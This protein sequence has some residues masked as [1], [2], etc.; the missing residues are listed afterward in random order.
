[1]QPD[2]GFPNWNDIPIE[3]LSQ[4]EVLKGAAS[5]L[6][7]SAA[8]NGIINFRSSFVKTEPETRFS[9]SSTVFL[10]P[11]DIAKKWWKDTLRYEN[12]FTFV[13]KQKFGKLDLIASGLYNK[14]EGFNQFT[15]ESR[16]RGNLNLRYRLTDRLSFQLGLLANASKSNSFFL[17]SNPGSGAMKPL[18]GTV[19]DKMSKRF[20]IDPSVTLYDKYNNKHRLLTRTILIDNQNNTNQSNTS[21]NQYCEYQFQRNFEKLKLVMTTGAVAAWSKTNSQILGDTTF[22][23]NNDALYLQLDKTFG[24]LIIAGGL[25]YEYVRQRSPENFMGTIIP[26]G[27]ASDDQLISRLSANYSFSEYSSLRASFGQ[28]YRYPTLTE[29]F[30]TTTFG[31]FSIFSNPKLRPEYG[32]SSEI[33]FKQGIKLGGFSGFLDGAVFMSE[34]EDMIEFTFVYEPGRFGFQPQNVGNTR[35][36]GYEVSILG[37]Q[38]IFGIPLIILGG[39]TY[40]N[41]VYKNYDASSQIRNSVSEQVNV[42]KYRSKHQFKMDVE[43]KIGKL[44]WGVSVQ[45]VSHVINIDKAF[46]KV[47]P[48]NIDL[49]GIGQYREFNANGYTLLDSR[50]SYEF[51]KLTVTG[52]VNNI[53]N[54]EYTLRPALIEAPRNIA[55]RLDFKLN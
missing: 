4:I 15:N 9:A 12:N 46:E 2:A 24:K 8:L 28:G 21:V 33:G 32:W 31:S 43:A 50:L 40:I 1:L 13:H 47:P 29:R 3:N 14:L 25:R 44:K 19:S 37:Q 5:T 30:V 53:L 17:W 16:G 41:P 18:P 55:I 52:L 38:N 6:Y 54:S 35:I 26:G 22:Y 51:G 39:Y 11:K 36:S 49:F 20:Y 23:A 27:K 48:I 10:S 7:G 45:K 42:L 34:Y